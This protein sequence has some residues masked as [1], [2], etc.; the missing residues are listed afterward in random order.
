M[1]DFQVICY[2][3]TMLRMTADDLPPTRQ[4]S[5]V[6]PSAPPGTAPDGRSG[7]R[8]ILA[9]IERERRRSGLTMTEL[10]RAAGLPVSTVRTALAPGAN[11]QLGTLQRLAHGLDLELRLTLPG[12]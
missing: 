1:P 3:D 2:T 8:S 11:P 5:L 12:E 4:L 9:G 10:A 6:T 7:R